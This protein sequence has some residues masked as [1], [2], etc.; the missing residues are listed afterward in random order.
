MLQTQSTATT[1]LLARKFVINLRM[2]TSKESLIFL[3]YID[4]IINFA[5]DLEE[6]FVCPS[7]PDITP[8]TG[9]LTRPKYW[10]VASVM[11]DAWDP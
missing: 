6:T 4:V 9:V 7:N 10:A 5:I 1:F 11:K 2:Y 3:S 8:L